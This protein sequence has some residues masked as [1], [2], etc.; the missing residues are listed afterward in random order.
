VAVAWGRYDAPSTIFLAARGGP[1]RELVAPSLGGIAP[2]D[3]PLAD[4]RTLA[5]LIEA[6]PFS[7]LERLSA[8]L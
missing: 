2:A 7:G 8:P 5:E 3:L 1:A 6:C 4:G